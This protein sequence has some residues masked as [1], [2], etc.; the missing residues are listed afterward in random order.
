MALLINQE[1]GGLAENDYKAFIAFV[2]RRSVSINFLKLNVKEDLYHY[3]VIGLLEAWKKFDPQRNVKFTTFSFI[4]V[5]RNILKGLKE[6]NLYH[7]LNE[8]IETETPD[9]A[10]FYNQIETRDI[11]QKIRTEIKNLPESEKNVLTQLYVKD[12]S[13]GETAHQ[14]GYKKPWVSKLHTKAVKRLQK[15]LKIFFR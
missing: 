9:P 12:L 5:K 11:L 13:L 14:L 8:E 10:I 2:I 15:R 7:F 1:I 3:G 6:M 4:Y